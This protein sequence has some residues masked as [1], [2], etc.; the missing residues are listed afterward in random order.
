MAADI[1]PIAFVLHR[2]ADAADVGDILL[3]DRN[4]FALLGE[5][6]AC[7]KPRGARAYDR[8]IRF[9]FAAACAPRQ[10]GHVLPPVSRLIGSERNWL[11][12]S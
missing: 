1:E 2:A 9:N 8:N 5:Q 7:S 3:D 4:G 10:I 12:P 11:A 6:I